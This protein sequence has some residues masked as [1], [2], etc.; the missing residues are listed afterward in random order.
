MTA[1]QKHVAFFDINKDGVIWWGWRVVLAL[2][3]ICCCACLPVGDEQW[4]VRHVSRQHMRMRT[5]Q[6]RA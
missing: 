6:T 2:S 4:V 3:L 1:L 5:R